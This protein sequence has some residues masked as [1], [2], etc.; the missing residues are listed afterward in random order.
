MTLVIPFYQVL[1]VYI[2]GGLPRIVSRWVSLPF[3]QILQ[4]APTPMMSVVDDGLDL[5]FF[6]IFD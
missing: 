6:L 5:V 1:R 4:L 2:F 3:D